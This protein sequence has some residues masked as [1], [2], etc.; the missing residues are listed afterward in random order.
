MEKLF[1]GQKISDGGRS[2]TLVSYI[3]S[4]SYG[5]VWRATDDYNG[6]NVAIKFYI[7]LDEHGR[8]EFMSEY[9]IAYGLSNPNLLTASH[10]GV[11]E[12]RPFLVMRYCPDGSAARL[13]GTL[14][15][16]PDNERTVWRFIRDVASG[17]TC[18]HNVAPDPIVHQDIKPDNIL[19]DTDGG[20]VITDFGI[21]KKIRSTMRSQSTRAVKA[22]AVA[23]MAPER[24]SKAPI[25]IMASDIWSLG[26]SVYELTMG[27]LPFSGLGGNMQRNGADTPELEGGWSRELDHVVR[28]CM[29]KEP[30]D[31]PKAH[32][33]V[34]IA[35]GIL[36]GK[37][38]DPRKTPKISGDSVGAFGA[39]EAK[40]EKRSKKQRKNLPWVIGSS[41]VAVTVAVLMLSGSDLKYRREARQKQSDYLA[42]VD[43]CSANIANGN[44]AKYQMLLDA[45][46]QLSDIS[47]YE[48]L[49]DSYYPKVYKE[50]SR[51]N[52]DLNVKLQEASSAWANAASS[53]NR[54]GNVDNALNYYHL[55]AQLY[56]AGS[57]SREFENLAK[58]RAYMKIRDIEFGNYCDGNVIDNYGSTLYA[59]S[60]KYLYPRVLYDG[61]CTSNKDS[62]DLYVKI[63]DPYGTVER[64]SSSPSG[65]TYKDGNNTIYSGNDQRLVLIGW[66]NKNVGSY[67]PGTYRFEVWYEGNKLFTKSFTI[68]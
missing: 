35:D 20:F 41:V 25:P 64:N 15:P 36:N 49:Y 17:L 27:E 57:A 31:R 18:L 51:L 28:K 13:V 5:E 32:E 29:S 53:Q 22:G 63:I 62:I 21:S 11:W 19:V 4:G 54:I 61:L 12:N 2:Y 60:L 26:A 14:M 44:K 59:S 68:Y 45:K 34:E 3:G 56:P 16:N 42:L 50:Y 37:S 40:G 33:L 55:A 38:Y 46:E 67:D 39:W 8:Q 10:I 66:G 24:F 6:E 30:W 9:E 65:Y 7:M 52:A 43:S 1:E 48:L 23:Y 58:K 47:F